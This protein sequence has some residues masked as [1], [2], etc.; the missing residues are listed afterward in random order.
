MKLEN[1]IIRYY[2]FVT[3]YKI[4]HKPDGNPVAEFHSAGKQTLDRWLLGLFESSIAGLTDS[5]SGLPQAECRDHAEKK[6]GRK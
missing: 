2:I 5:N 1:K 4:S 6:N 3:K